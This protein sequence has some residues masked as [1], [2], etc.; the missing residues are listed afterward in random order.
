MEECLTEKKMFLKMSVYMKSIHNR[1]FCESVTLCGVVEIFVQFNSL[2]LCCVYVFLKGLILGVVLQQS[3]DVDI[4]GK[5]SVRRVH[6]ECVVMM[7][8]SVALR[9]GHVGDITKNW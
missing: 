2:R 6:R 1:H 8:F 4:L 3:T 7:V 9:M 5:K